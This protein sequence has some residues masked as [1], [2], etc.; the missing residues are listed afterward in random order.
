MI[1]VLKKLAEMFGDRY[2]DEN[3]MLTGTHTHSGPGAYHQYVLFEITSMGM[4][5]PSLDAMVDGIVKVKRPLQYRDAGPDVN[6]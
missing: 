4:Y 6:I 3:I 1:Q 2:T 5:K